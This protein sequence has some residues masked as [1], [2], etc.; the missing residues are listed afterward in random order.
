MS[1][2]LASAV[3]VENVPLGSCELKVPRLGIGTLQWGH[4]GL[5]LDFFFL[6]CWCSGSMSHTLASAV[7]VERV[8]LGGSELRVPK[9]GIGTLQW[10]DPGS[11]FGEKYSEADLKEAY[12]LLT[13]AGL[14]FFDSAEVSGRSGH[15]GSTSLLAEVSGRRP[16]DLNSWN[17]QR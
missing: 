6:C 2:I 10:G 14:D 17:Q 5:F 3:E 13:S 9:L 16:E 1:Y 8:P 12:D 4:R 15:W 7:E 11:G